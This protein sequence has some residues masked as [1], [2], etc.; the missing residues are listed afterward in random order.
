VKATLKKWV[1]IGTTSNRP[2]VYM[3]PIKMKDGTSLYFYLTSG[4]A[5]EAVSLHL[6]FGLNNKYVTELDELSNEGNELVRAFKKKAAYHKQW[7]LK[8]F[9][10]NYN[11][12]I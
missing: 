11:L 3:T 12:Y 5:V 7:A 1:S 9:I 2:A 8:D 10:S 4:T 6:A